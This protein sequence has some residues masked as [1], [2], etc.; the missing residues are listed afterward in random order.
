[1]SDFTPE[2]LFDAVDR[3]VLDLLSKQGIEEP[4]VD[5]LMLVQKAFGYAVTIEEA[6]EDEEPRQYGDRPPPRRRGRELVLKPELSA[7]GR[8]SMAARACAKEL[9]PPVLSKLG[10]APGTEQRGA[11][12]QLIGVIAPRLL[13]PTRWFARDLRKAN[14]D[15]ARLRERYPTVAYETLA[16]RILDQDEPCVIAIVDDG[17]VTTRR[18][19]GTA[20]TKVLTEAE[21]K[22]IEQVLEHREP[23]TVRFDDWT[24]RGWAIPGGP[25]N[26]IILRSVPDELY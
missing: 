2:E 11:A 6:E 16:L 14:N 24:A 19:N 5:A 15:L 8:N 18:S 9:I 12:T 22:C 4:P 7:A 13:L 23:R 10:I 20:V 1:M 26:R 21:R 3:I 25:F 17:T